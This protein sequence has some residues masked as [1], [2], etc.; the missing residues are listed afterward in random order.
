[1]NH[2]ELVMYHIKDSKKEKKLMG[3]CKRLQMQTRK[4]KSGDVNCSVGVLAGFPEMAVRTAQKAPMGYQL[5][6]LL[7][8][9]GMP[10]KRLDEFLA[11]YR[12]ESIEPVGLKA[13]ITPQNVHW[14]LYELTAELVKERAAIIMGQSR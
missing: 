8:F 4:I 12:T 7:V 5:P 11:E 13:I 9:S 1:M 6:E 10:E 2:T 3:L 14:S